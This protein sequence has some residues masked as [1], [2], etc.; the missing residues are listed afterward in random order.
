MKAQIVTEGIVLRRVNFQETSRILTILT[1]DHG[2]VALI[3]KGVRRSKSKLAG[4]IE[5]F[6][7]SQ[8]TFLPGKKD[9]GTLIS[10][11][12]KNH[13]GHI[14]KDINKTMLGYELL[15]HVN[16][17]TE[18]AAGEEYFSLLESGL[19]GLNN[20]KLSVELVEL[21]FNMH[22]LKVSGHSP[23]LKTDTSGNALASNQTYIFDNDNM[24]FS[25]HDGGQIG[26][27]HIKLLRLGIGTAEPDALLKVQG[28]EKHL[29]QTLAVS[30][31][32]LSRYVRL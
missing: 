15:K 21:W 8:I 27:G 11:R 10:T 26:S 18:E 30:K 20:Q 32:M 2:K 5:L 14:V 13:Y 6:S 28:V 24:S 12:L 4:G 25:L 7:V 3:A 23:N 31:S 19:T 16:Q 9:I 17:I 1:P 29:S 22:L